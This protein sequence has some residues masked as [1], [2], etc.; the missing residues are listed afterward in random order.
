MIAYYVYDKKKDDDRIVLPEA[1]CSVKVTPEAFEKFI[2]V[3][4]EFATWTG[5]SC[6]N[7]TP[8]H[9]GTIVA[10]RADGGD[11]SIQKEELWRE[12][13]F[14]FMSGAKKPME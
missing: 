2:A 14:F 1:G 11:V 9:F 7:L 13:M 5:D 8:E 6:A 4:P 3:K 12:R 10:Q